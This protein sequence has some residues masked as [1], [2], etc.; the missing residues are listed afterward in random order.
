MMT[1][2]EAQYCSHRCS[3]CA[4]LTCHIERVPTKH[5][6]AAAVVVADVGIASAVVVD[7]DGGGVVVVVV[8]DGGGVV[9]HAVGDCEKRMNVLSLR[10]VLV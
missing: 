5:A 2:C 6:A 8:V 10:M 3:C 1:S 9:V 4:P 7:D